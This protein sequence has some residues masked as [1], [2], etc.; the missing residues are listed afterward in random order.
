[1][2]LLQKAQKHPSPSTV[3]LSI[4]PPTSRSPS[5][6]KHISHVLPTAGHDQL[7]HRLADLV[8]PTQGGCGTPWREA[9]LLSE[10]AFW[11]LM[12]VRQADGSLTY[13]SIASQHRCAIEPPMPPPCS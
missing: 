3:H 11:L 1:M 9:R 4:W 10:A 8:E 6:Y 7:P 12:H 2:Q 5:L 13:M